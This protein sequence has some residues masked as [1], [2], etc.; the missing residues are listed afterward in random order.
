M[1]IEKKTIRKLFL[2]AVGCII[3]YWILHETERVARMMDVVGGI[4][5]P[6][7][8][9][10][11]LA[12]IVNV[13][14]RALERGL[15]FVKKPGLRR[16]FAMLLTVV[17]V[18]LVLAGV[19]VLLIPQITETFMSLIPKLTS[20]FMAVEERVRGFLENN[21]RLMELIYSNTEFENLD[22]AGLIQK[23]MG[24]VTS[25]ISTIAVGTFSAVGSITGGIVDTVIGLVF[26]VY[27][28]SRKE[29]L[30]RQG[31]RIIYSFLPERFCDEVIRI[32]RLTN[33][34]FCNF[35]SGQCL[36]A[37]ILACLFAVTMAILRMPYITLIS[38]LIGVT[39]LIP[40]V[41]AFVGCALGAFFILVNDPFQAVVFVI[42]FLIL[43][44]IENNMIYPK[45]VGTSIGLPGMWV[46][47]AVGVGGEIMGVA[48]MFIMIP[49][50]AVIYTLARE[51][52][53]KR[54]A[55]RGIDPE[56]LK[57]QPPEIKSHFKEKREK[58]KKAALLQKLQERKEHPGSDENN[59]EHN[60]V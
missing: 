34:T 8:I 17:V 4:F 48:G 42:M 39:A 19:V 31:R 33:R 20:F 24:V 30:A 13:P 5:R 6:F 36:E 26:M 40:V 59:S 2:T 56:K 41:G 1:Q 22:W 58:K 38:V 60:G 10:S 21:P 37:C 9:G 50:M 35:L 53:S 28:L 25:G 45:V 3:L 27:C 43:Q 18:I 23:V 54:V 46:L 47:F 44:Q 29:I 14:M 11:A 15:R 49:V 52:T 57:D 7:V 32:L 12:F 55:E 51:V 16:S